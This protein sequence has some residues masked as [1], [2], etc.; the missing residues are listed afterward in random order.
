MK[1]VSI[2][3]ILGAGKSSLIRHLLE[4]A[5]RRG[6]TA[7]A[8]VND[9]GEVSLDVPEIRSRHPVRRIGGG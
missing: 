7:G 6:M 2:I 8:V 3:G 4:E 1:V 9:N 5:D